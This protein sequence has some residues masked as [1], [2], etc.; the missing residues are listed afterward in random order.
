M[1]TYDLR[2]FRVTGGKLNKRTYTFSPIQRK[3]I[4]VINGIYSDQLQEIF[5]R[6]TGL[7]THL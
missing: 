1:D 7:Y 4:K 3:D 2:F 6:V 5:T